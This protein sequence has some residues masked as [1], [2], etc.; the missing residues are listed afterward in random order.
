MEKLLE[1]NARIKEEKKGPLV[2]TRAAGF[3]WE[4]PSQ[5]NGSWQ[6]MNV[7]VRAICI[8]HFK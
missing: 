1:L 5:V 7:A 4:W 2:H 6:N 8:V 3:A